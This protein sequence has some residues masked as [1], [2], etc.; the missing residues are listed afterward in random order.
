MT[1]KTIMGVKPSSMVK[2][3]VSADKLKKYGKKEIV[4]DCEVKGG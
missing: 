1:S 2:L 3:D 4:V